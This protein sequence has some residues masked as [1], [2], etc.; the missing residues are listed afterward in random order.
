MVTRGS[1]KPLLW[2]RIL[3][4]LPDF[5]AFRGKRD[6]LFLCSLA[7]DLSHFFKSISVQVDVDVVRYGHIGVSKQFWQNLNIASSVVPVR[8]EGVSECMYAPIINVRLLASLLHCPSN[9]EIW[10]R[11]IWIAQTWEDIWAVRVPILS[12]SLQNIHR[13][14]GKWD[15]PVAGFT[16]RGILYKRDPFLRRQVYECPVDSDC[17]LPPQNII[18]LKTLCFP[19]SQ[20]EFQHEEFAL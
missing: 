13:C 6:A 7:N 20:A 17:F 12:N 10:D 3:L 15:S 4:P 2:V 18:P 19:V 5:R 8:S 16:F 14:I 1:P 11:H 9:G